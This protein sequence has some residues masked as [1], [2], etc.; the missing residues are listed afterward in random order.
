MG[1]LSDRVVE[2]FL[3]VGGRLAEPA[4]LSDELQ[5]SSFD[6]F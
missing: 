2:G 5:S 6:F 3:V 4:D 1:D